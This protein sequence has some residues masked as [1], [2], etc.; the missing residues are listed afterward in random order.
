MTERTKYLLTING[1]PA[2][3]IGGQICY[4]RIKYR[5]SGVKE[6]ELANSPRH[7]RQL[8][9]KTIKYRRSQNFI[10]SDADEIVERHKYG[11]LPIRLGV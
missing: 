4:A 1:H 9:E 7:V 10:R 11:Y 8:V 6:S 3:F 5:G 2:Y